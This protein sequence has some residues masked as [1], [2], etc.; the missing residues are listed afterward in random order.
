MPDP[1]STSSGC[2]YGVWYTSG[3]T[4]V[5]TGLVNVTGSVV[6]EFA[7]ADTVY[8]NAFVMNAPALSV[9]L[10]VKL[11]DPSCRARPIRLVNPGARLPPN[12]SPGSAIAT[13]SG[14]APESSVHVYGAVPQSR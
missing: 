11:N 3:V 2:E 14:S 1:P 6:Y 5:F 13:P 12:A 7:R 8:V 4:T 10:I 9:T